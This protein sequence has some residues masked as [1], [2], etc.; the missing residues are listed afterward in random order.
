MIKNFKINNYDILTDKRVTAQVSGLTPA[1]STP[2]SASIGG[3]KKVNAT[4]RSNRTISVSGYIRYEIA[5]TVNDIYSNWLIGETVTIEITMD[6]GDI[7]T[8]KAIIKQ[9]D[10]DRYKSTVPIACLIECYSAFFYKAPVTYDASSTTVDNCDI[11]QHSF[12]ITHQIQSDETEFNI[13]FF[14][15]TKVVL[16]GDYA[17]QIAVINCEEQT[18]YI[19]DVNK[20][21]LVKEWQDGSNG[22]VN[23]PAN[24]TIEYNKM[25]R[26][27][28]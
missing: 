16:D 18:C 20:F 6:N 17:G 14:G 24:T 25:V 9:L 11:E 21:Y 15:A 22:N 8:E 7:F 4:I 27:L 12:V 26:G 2:S 1:N 13:D 5:E 10:I 23:I 19:N 28:W 3:N